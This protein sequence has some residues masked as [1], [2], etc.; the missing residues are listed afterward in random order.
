[1]RELAEKRAIVTDGA[2][3]IGLAV[4][5]CLGRLRG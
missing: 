3:G 5:T 1:M 2:S 4:Q